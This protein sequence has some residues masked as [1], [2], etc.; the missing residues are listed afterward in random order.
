[1]NRRD[2]RSERRRKAFLSRQ[3]AHHDH[4]PDERCVCEGGTPMEFDPD[5]PEW[6]L[7]ALNR[8]SGLVGFHPVPGIAGGEPLP[9]VEPLED[10]DDPDWDFMA[11][12]RAICAAGVKAFIRWASPADQSPPGAEGLFTSELLLVTEIAPGLRSRIDLVP[13]PPPDAN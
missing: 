6:D 7:K 9:F 5:H 4:G 1:M 8:I 12:D 11:F 13:L 3:G 10:W 2:R